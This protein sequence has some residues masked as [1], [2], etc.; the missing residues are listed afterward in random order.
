MFQA[1]RSA[2]TQLLA[3]IG[4]RPP[5]YDLTLFDTNFPLLSQPVPTVSSA[6][7][8]L[9]AGQTTDTLTSDVPA[10]WNGTDVD[11]IL[12]PTGADP[13]QPAGTVVASATA[14]GG[15]ATAQWTPN[16]DLTPGTYCPRSP[17]SPRPVSCRSRRPPPA[18]SPS[19]P[20]RRTRPRLPARAQVPA[21]PASRSSFRPRSI[22]HN[23]GPTRSRPAGLTSR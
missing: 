12:F 17:T 21:R 19:P 5:S 14:A 8:T 22:S 9:A 20:A 16:A 23:P 18:R 7:A 2:L 4:I 6:D 15:V 3:W 13:S 10:S 1:R 11:F